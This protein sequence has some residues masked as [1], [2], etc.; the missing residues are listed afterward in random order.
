MPS[1][2]RMSTI[3]THSCV[4]NETPQKAI[5][6]PSPNR[7]PELHSFWISSIRS[8]TWFEPHTSR[9]SHL[10]ST[11]SLFNN[12]TIIL[13][14]LVRFCVLL[15][16]LLVASENTRKVCSF[17]MTLVNSKITVCRNNNKVWKG[18]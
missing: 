11:Q 10:Y 17:R 4:I 8:Y 12:L 14:V 3:S 2:S 5:K 15:P 1:L 9:R 13:S 16:I 6:W 7:M 18:L